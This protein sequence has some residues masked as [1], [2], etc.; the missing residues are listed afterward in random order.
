MFARPRA[1][2]KPTVGDV[3]ERV[4]ADVLARTTDVAEAL[5]RRVDAS[6]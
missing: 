1:R 4:D 3:V 6:A 2:V 5:V